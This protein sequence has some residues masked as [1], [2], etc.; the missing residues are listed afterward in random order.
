MGTG[1]PTP[2]FL[3]IILLRPLLQCTT[4]SSQPNNTCSRL[5][6]SVTHTLV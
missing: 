5:D 3:T 4:E 6:D 2:S 1:A